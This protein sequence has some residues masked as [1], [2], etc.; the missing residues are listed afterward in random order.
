MQNKY[1]ILRLKPNPYPIHGDL[2]KVIDYQA[3][4]S[5]EPTI[6]LACAK[7]RDLWQ[8]PGHAQAQ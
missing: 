6:L 5:P 4:S 7:D 8:G 3:F 2:T 1:N